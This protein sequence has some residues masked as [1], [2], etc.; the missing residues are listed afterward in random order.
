VPVREI[1]TADDPAFV[2]AHRLLRRMFPR[3][4]LLPVR[5]WAGTL[6]ERHH[7]LW[8]DLS[9][10]LLV[11][12]R[13]SE[14]LGTASGSYLGNV[15]VGL[16]GYVAVARAAR[17]RG[18]GHRLRLRLRRLLER[19]AR[20][21]HGR[22]LKALVGEVRADN[23]W[24]GHVVREEG[25]LALDFAYLQPSLGAR[26]PP[27]ELVLYYQPLHARRRSLSTAEVRRLLYTIWRRG[28]RIGRPLSKL[29]FRRMLD[30]LAG[31]DRV[32][33]RPLASGP[34]RKRTRA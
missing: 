27:V 7:R 26:H 30:G 9:W 12:E 31:R 29:A 21:V 8:T 11:A 20:R 2:A 6:L 18:L 14:V 10:H 16:V 24:L 5:E 17:G 3:R 4:E 19:D 13:H 15:N 32:G 23:P 1:R 22:D 25:A 33:Q 28:Y 34:A